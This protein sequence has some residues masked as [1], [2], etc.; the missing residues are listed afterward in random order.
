MRGIMNEDQDNIS[1]LQNKLNELI[2]KQESFKKDIDD[3]QREIF[4]LR[5]LKTEEKPE[6]TLADQTPAQ[7][8][9]IQVEEKQL[10][11]E[12][13]GTILEEEGPD[14]RVR[15]EKFIGENLINKIGIIITVIGV[16]IGA[17]Y[18]IDHQL[19]SP[20]TRIILG[21]LLG[22]GLLGFAIRLRRKYENFSAVLL[23]GSMAIM[24]FIT[25]AAYSFYSLIPLTFAFVLMVLFTIFTVAAAIRYD[26][27]VIAHIGLVG[28]Y[29]VPFLLSED[30]GKVVILFSYM[31]IIN[32]GILVIA[33]RKYWKPLY[34]SSFLLTWIIFLTWYIPKYETANHFGLSWI[35]I[36]IF[37]VTF[38]IIFL[39]YKL[40]KKEKFAIEDIL[41]LLAN[42]SVFYGLGY[43]ILR[44]HLQGEDFQ[45]LF[46]LGNALIHMVVSILI[47]RQKQADR[48][49]FFFIVGLSLAFLTIAIPVQLDGN[50]V[51]LLWSAEAAM[52]FWIGRTKNASV[53][54]LLSYPLMILAFFSITLGWPSVYHTASSWPVG[55]KIIPLA[56]INFLTS[57]IFIVSFAF[58][59][60]LNQ[61]RQFKTP[62]Q[63]QETLMQIMNFIIPGM[64][65]I[66]LYFAFEM[67]IVTFWKQHYANTSV[68]LDKG[69]QVMQE[70]HNDNILPYKIISVLIYSLLFFSVL[71]YINILK[72]K[73]SLL[74]LINLGFNAIVV[75]S[76]LTVGLFVLGALRE[77]YLSQTLSE[78]YYRGI[79]DIGIRYFSF[80]FVAL[81]LFAVYTYIRQ[82]FLGRD[83]HMGFDF[84][85][86]VTVLTIASNELINWMDL[87]GSEQSYKLGLSILWGVYAL[88]LIVL[89]IWKKKLHL[90]IGAIVLF[91]VTL[92]KLF[93]YDLTYLDTISKTIVFVILGLLLLVISFLYTKY[94]KV[95]FE[96]RND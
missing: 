10:Q 95:I 59:N 2:N 44:R 30:S 18:A 58:I 14:F 73:K 96:D 12:P 83:L 22:L 39:A 47:Y 33:F 29:A 64:L 93:F 78:Y 8:T 66:V 49:L 13:E 56:N 32:A 36:S 24:Y 54:E 53:Y 68:M 11:A 31:A 19:I 71:S 7:P 82:E 74:G 38:Y 34:Y 28:A 65:L 55:E 79:M 41:L 37:F 5:T 46:T 43:S 16:G 50:W 57:T 4:H 27:Q 87:L 62:L 52:L 90:R 69:Y 75:V 77:N 6:I 9:I 25:F 26:K 40:L 91:S 35:F 1:Q 81:M 89:G 94:R 17:K 72:L 85:L 48:N 20:W 80:A 61:N 23:S 92:I 86:H 3:L 15:L 60:I 51:T 84:L 42:S 63:W 45:G 70:I 67:E 88:L 21:Y 76:F